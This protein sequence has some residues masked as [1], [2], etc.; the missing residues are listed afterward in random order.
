MQ[1]PAPDRYGV[2]GHPV[3][4]SRS[5]LI[6]GLFAR[7]T[8]QHLVYRLY[9]IS[10]ENF[11]RDVAAF[12]AERVVTRRSI[13][14]MLLAVMLAFLHIWNKMSL[15]FEAMHVV[16]AEMHAENIELWRQLEICRNS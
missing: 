7:Q 1:E 8:R 6:H 16:L 5:P 9:D 14:V 15:E 11:A 10:P 4:H 3:A 13:W 2:V 12:F